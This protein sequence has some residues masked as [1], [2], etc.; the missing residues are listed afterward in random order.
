VASYTVEATSLCGTVLSNA[1]TLSIIQATGITTQPVNQTICIGANATFTVTAAGDNLNY[2]WRKAGVNIGGANSSSYTITGVAAGDAG[3]YDVVVSG[4]CGNVTSNTV[5]LSLGNVAINTQPLSQTVCTGANVTFIVSAVGSSISYQW[6]KDGV[7]ISG[8]VSSSY[9]ING[10]TTGNAGGYDV[11]VTG[12]CD[13][14][15]STVAVLTINT[16]PAISAQPVSQSICPGS[17][18]TFNVTATGTALTYQWRK[19]GVNISGATASSYTINNAVAGDAGN[20]DV[21]ISGVCPP[22]VTSSAAVLTILQT[23]A[24]TTHPLTQ[25]TFVGSSVTFSVVATGSG[26]TYQWRKDGTDIPGATGSSYTI[27]NVAL[28][29]AGSYDVVV[30][31]TCAPAVTS[32][33][34][35][36]TVSTV[37]IT[38]QPVNVAVCEGLNATF[39]VAASGTNLSYQWQVSSG[40]GAFTNINGATSASLT[41]NAVTTSMSGNQ[42]RCVVGGSLN[43]NAATLTVHPLPVVT[44]AL[45]FD[46]ISQSTSLFQLSGGSPA[47]GIYTGTGINGTSFIPAAVPVGNYSVTYSFTNA[48]G[49]RSTATDNFTIIPNVNMVSLFPNPAQEGKVTIIVSSEFVGG[50]AVVY[51]SNGQKVADWRI[52]G[53]YSSYTFKW[54]GGIYIFDFSNGSNRVTKKLVIT[55]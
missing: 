20:Y 5:S 48:N 44:L 15:T 30:S 9:T 14:V 52:V 10:V 23:P 25:A 34:A 4:T 11:V 39:T 19:G 2:Q 21:V 18:V 13:A 7:I 24:I 36:L 3:S 55:R 17:N 12:D 32:N 41:L 53:R 31:G 27:N 49:C 1:A 22:A 40:G 42:Y 26:L 33:S 46:T 35:I 8:A 16:P 54:P 51:N 50:T 47:G 43:S 28:T 37:T 6:R 29:D 45:P 38:T